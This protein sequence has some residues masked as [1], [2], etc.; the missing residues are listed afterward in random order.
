MDF[1][2]IEKG[3]FDVRDRRIKKFFIFLLLY[4]NI[5]LTPVFAVNEDFYCQV[6]RYGT[7]SDIIHSFSKVSGDLGPTVN[8]KVIEIFKEDHGEGVYISIARYIGIA[9]LKETCPILY[10]ELN[11]ARIS[12][13]YRE[14]LI[15]TLGKLKEPSSVDFLKSYYFDIKRTKRIRKAIIDA[16]GEIG[17]S[18]IEDTLISLINNEYE[19]KEL[20]GSAI[21]SIG[22]AGTERSLDLLRDIATN[23]QE[24]KILRIYS[25]HSLAKLG[26]EK[27][28]DI[29]GALIKDESHEVAE[30]AVNGMVEI[31]SKNCGDYLLLALK[32][33][34]DKVRIYA[35]M[36]LAVIK[37][38][39]AVD[40][41]KFK[42]EHDV[43]ERVREEAK[44]ALEVIQHSEDN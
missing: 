20:R 43:N 9:G 4:F 11:K 34:Y 41:L 16:W 6:L 36:G 28:I 8:G 38:E 14:E 17:D 18:R 30:Y 23:P 21:L 27:V 31:G 33:N 26:G 29:L 25:I 7:D 32:S 19:D 24:E 37:Y 39:G 10:D 5:I 3:W 35:A 15:L 44:K 42:S 22:K 40:I 12:E 13:D 1:L 2:N